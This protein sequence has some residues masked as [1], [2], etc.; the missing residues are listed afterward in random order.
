M[1]DN[2]SPPLKKY[3][4]KRQHRFLLPQGKSQQQWSSCNLPLDSESSP[5][6][7]KESSPLLLTHRGFN[8]REPQPST[9]VNANTTQQQHQ[10]HH[11]TQPHAPTPRIE[12]YNTNTL[13]QQHQQHHRTQPH[14][15]TP[16]IQNYTNT[17]QHYRTQPTRTQPH[18][19]PTPRT[20]S[21]YNTITNNRRSQSLTFTQQQQQHTDNVLVVPCRPSSTRSLRTNSIHKYHSV[22][23]AANR[24]EFNI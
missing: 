18:P 17:Q 22:G 3:K 21:N 24:P 1:S 10:Q 19:P 16:R 20:E 12:N 2:E 13:Q 8:K 11:R 23:Y 5:H 14:P 15:P 7:R 6:H 4:G 9:S